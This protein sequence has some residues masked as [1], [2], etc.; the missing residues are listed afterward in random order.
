MWKC[1]LYNLFVNIC[2]LYLTFSNLESIFLHS[3]KSKQY[4]GRKWLTARTILFFQ[5]SFCFSDW[6][7]FFWSFHMWYTAM[8]NTCYTFFAII[9][10]IATVK[11]LQSLRSF[12]F[13]LLSYCSAGVSEVYSILIHCRSLPHLK[14]LSRTIPDKHTLNWT[15]SYLIHWAKLHP[16]L[17]HSRS[18]TLLSYIAQ[19][20]TFSIHRWRSP[21]GKQA[22]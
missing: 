19:I 6:V 8:G 13:F 18:H 22:L 7:L 4:K 1:R 17:I 20:Y 16:I 5:A 12:E 14:T 21:L 15:T 9:F 2:T 10:W 3:I 11:L